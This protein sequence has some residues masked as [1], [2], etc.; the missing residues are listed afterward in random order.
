MSPSVK[1]LKGR[2]VSQLVHGQV[3]Q[4]SY[5]GEETPEQKTISFNGFEVFLHLGHPT[6]QVTLFPFSFVLNMSL[7][8]FSGRDNVSASGIVDQL[9]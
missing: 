4:A 7:H 9:G 1:E 5:T 8:P 3:L 2:E 6:W